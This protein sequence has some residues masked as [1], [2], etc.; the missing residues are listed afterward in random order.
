VNVFFKFLGTVIAG[1]SLTRMQETVLGVV[2]P[3]VLLAIFE[4]VYRN[5]PYKVEIVEEGNETPADD[6]MASHGRRQGTLAIKTVAYA[7]LGVGAMIFVLGILASHGRT[8]VLGISLLIILLGVFLL[9]MPGK[10]NK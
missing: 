6:D 10:K 2:L 1:I 5:K 3:I 7:L 8:S 9:W 4:I